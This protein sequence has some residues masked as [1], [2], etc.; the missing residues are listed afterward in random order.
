MQQWH[1]EPMRMTEAT[2]EE[3]VDNRQRHQKTKQE[4]GAMSGKQGD[5]I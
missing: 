2:S 5:I 4:T 1:K 3:G